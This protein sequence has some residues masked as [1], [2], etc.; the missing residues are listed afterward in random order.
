MPTDPATPAS[1]PGEREDLLGGTQ[2]PPG[3]PPPG[4]E[5]SSLAKEMREL[6]ELI[7]AQAAEMMSLKAQLGIGS[8]QT[9]KEKEEGGEDYNSKKLKPIDI[10]DIK[11][12]SEYD[13][14]VEDFVIW[15]ERL[16][17]LMTNRHASWTPVL[18]AIEDKKGER[19]TDVKE[20]I[21]GIL[22]GHIEEQW[23]T[24]LQQLQSYLRTYTKGSMFNRINKT[25]KEDIAEAFRDIIQKGRSH[26]KKKLCR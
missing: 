10:K 21:F 9:P 13:G 11:K 2:A 8:S 1:P 14:K 26:N 23:E 3:I 5:E 16:K 25:R 6:K 4:G 24:Y 18:K 19:I 12:P 7:K 22:D 15:Y 17:D 20:E